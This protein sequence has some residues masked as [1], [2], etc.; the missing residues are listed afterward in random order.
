M[1]KISKADVIGTTIED[2]NSEPVPEPVPEH[3]TEPD[4]NLIAKC[5][6]EYLKVNC[7]TVVFIY[8]CPKVGSTS[9]VS[10]FRIFAAKKINVFHYHNENLFPPEYKSAGIT[11]NHLIHYCATVLNKKV[12]VIDVY[13]TPIEKKISTYFDRL[14]EY[15]FNVAPSVLKTY[16]L[17]K[18]I[19]RFN[20]LFPHIANKDYLFDGQYGEKVHKM[21][22][23][24]EMELKLQTQLHINKYMQF[25]CGMVKYV[26]L[27]LMDSDH[28]GSILSTIFGIHMEIV[29][30]YNRD[31]MELGDLYRSFKKE[32]KI[33][34]QFLNDI[35]DN[36]THFRYYLSQTE[37]TAY[38]SKWNVNLM[39]MADMLPVVVPYT[40]AEYAFYCRLCEENK[41]SDFVQ[42]NEEHY[43]DAGCI[44]DACMATRKR[45]AANII[46][47]PHQPLTTK[48]HH[49][50]SVKEVKTQVVRQQVVRKLRRSGNIR[51][52][53]KSR[54]R[55]SHIRMTLY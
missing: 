45:V 39:T 20:S 2:N 30:D 5:A 22:S 31:Q 37:Q 8:T 35:R 23:G 21:M 6:K 13:R 7:P 11:L 4:S 15:H 25:D 12:Y 50:N 33:P 18:I 46:A 19:H 40:S 27:R 55:S 42:S 24:S 48:I 49:Q 41:H 52:K 34:A 28:W 36:D 38:L 43:I 51:R 16:S 44:C 14:S 53:G 3:V 29:K 54:S 1:E 32:Y 17:D 26:K 9:L 10:T 47:H